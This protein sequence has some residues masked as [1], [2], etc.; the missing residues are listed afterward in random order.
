MNELTAARIKVA[1]D[2]EE[3]AL[4]AQDGGIPVIVRFT[5]DAPDARTLDERRA[6][7]RQRLASA[8]S[9]LGIRAFAEYR[10]SAMSA[11]FVDTRQLDALLDSG[12]AAAVWESKP[13]QAHLQQSNS[14][15]G[16]QVA[17]DRGLYGNGVA[18]V[19]LDTGIDAGHATF[20]GRV[21]WE[22]CFSTDLPAP[23]RATN[24][25]PAGTS[26]NGI[27][28]TQT[29][30]GAAALTKCIDVECWHGTHVA[31]IAAG[32]DATYTGMAP[33]A[34]II[35]IQVFSRFQS[36]QY[37]GP[38]NSPCILSFDHDQ[39][40]AL[41]YVAD[42]AAT[43]DIVA[44]NMSLGGGSY[45]SACDGDVAV[46]VA[47]MGALKALDIVVA[48]S[49]GNNGYT[50]AIGHPACLSDVISVGS[51]R[52]TDDIVSTFSNSA[53][54]LDIL[55]PGQPIT[56]AQA[57]G[58]FITASGT[59]MAAPHVTGA[60]ALLKAHD[61]A[62]THAEIRSLLLANGTPVLDSRNGLTFPR[63][64]LGLL[65]TAVASG[66]TGDANDDGRVDIADLL[67]IH[68]YLTG[69]ATLNS[70]AIQR[71]DV[72]PD[73]SPD[74]ILDISDLLLLQNILVTN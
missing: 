6:A 56:A 7:G 70:A 37:C 48:A 29:G 14:L 35:A 22:A 33:Q 63:L 45:L 26:E 59:S 51:V 73:G 32:S 43:Y 47:A 8:M 16:S 54:F 30:S 58:G 15:I 49:S 41:E 20:G 62:L 3:M 2:Y 72:Y 10:R 4:S 42:L 69:Q 34:N 68:R 60:I 66:L 31:S 27:Y 38:G 17:R 19:I 40:A 12:Y 61:N 11:F 52:D 46:L 39:L 64:D 13:R 25:C 53:T 5:V 9:R 67:L 28:F 71:C 1:P 57:G 65:A 21:T 18:V 36:T 55:A 24:L 50:T 44:V 23:Y 74:G